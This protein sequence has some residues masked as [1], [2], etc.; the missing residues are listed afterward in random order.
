MIVVSILGIIAVIVLFI[1]L[2]NTGSGCSGNC[3]QGRKEC[4]CENKR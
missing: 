3:N 2:D 4:D 1:K